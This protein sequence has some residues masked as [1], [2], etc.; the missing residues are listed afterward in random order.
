MDGTVWEIEQYGN[1]DGTVWECGWNSMGMW[2]EQ[3][4]NVDGTVWEIEQYGNVDGTVWD[5]ESLT[6]S[7]LKMM[8]STDTWAA[9]FSMSHTIT[10]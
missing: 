5:V 6:H 4:G 1:V 7:W 10:P 2:M 9:R 8:T 3:Y